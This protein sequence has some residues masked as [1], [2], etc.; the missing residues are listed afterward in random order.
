LPPRWAGRT[1]G[2]TGAD[3]ANLVDE[4][5][6]MTARGGRMRVAQ[7]DLEEAIMRVTSGPERR[8]HLVPPPE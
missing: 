6:I 2:L 5:A 8:S 7:S 1:A 4:A 3:L